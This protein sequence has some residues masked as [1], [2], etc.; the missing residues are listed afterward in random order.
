MDIDTAVFLDMCQ[1]QAT[2]NKQLGGY[3]DREITEDQIV[4]AF[5]VASVDVLGKQTPAKVAQG[6][7]ALHSLAM[8]VIY[9]AEDD[10]FT[11]IAEEG[12]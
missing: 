2:A 8:R 5:M 12:R 9:I 4:I 10:G 7:D 11:I 1:R 3:A 6:F